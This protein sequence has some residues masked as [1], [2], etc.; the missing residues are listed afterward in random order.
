MTWLYNSDGT[1]EKIDIF[2]YTYFLSLVSQTDRK[3][4]GLGK[5]L[6]TCMINKGLKSLT[7]KGPPSE[8]EKTNSLLEK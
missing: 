3:K 7:Q 6:A 5:I 4:N 1:K 8:K 2:D